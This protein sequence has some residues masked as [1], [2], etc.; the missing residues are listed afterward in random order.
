MNFRTLGRQARRPTT[1]HPKTQD[2]ETSSVRHLF[3]L[4]N[5]ICCGG[6]AKLGGQSRFSSPSLHA[7]SASDSPPTSTVFETETFALLWRSYGSVANIRSVKSAN[8]SRCAWGRML[9]GIVADGGRGDTCLTWWLKVNISRP[10]AIRAAC[11]HDLHI[12]VE[13]YEQNRSVECAYFGG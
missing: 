8:A 2:F 10:T 5:T 7:M 3:Y 6:A 9:P 13:H 1:A 11:M 12:L 4:P